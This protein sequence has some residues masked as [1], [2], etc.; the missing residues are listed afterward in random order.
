MLV[1]ENSLG[2][3][4]P[5]ADEIRGLIGTNN[6]RGNVGE[7]RWEMV[8]CMCTWKV[9]KA[10]L[11]TSP[12]FTS[13]RYSDSPVVLASNAFALLMVQHMK[14]GAP[15]EHSDNPFQGTIAQMLFYS[16]LAAVILNK[17]K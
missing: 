7:T 8:A 3:L 9:V 5:L 17:E 16:V 10:T 13:Q 4:D 2:K 14:D 6:S 11:H 15:E 12:S 1:V